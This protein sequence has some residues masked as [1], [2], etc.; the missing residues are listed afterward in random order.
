MTTE[1][2]IKQQ[3]SDNRIILYMKGIPK[4][5]QCG[6]SARAVQVLEA[7]GAEFAFVNVLEHPEI[8]Q[9]LPKISNWPTFPQL[10]VAGELIGGSDIIM[11]LYQ[12]GKL[13][14]VIADAKQIA[15]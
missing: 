5:P 6:F 14:K 12:E 7:C 9:T 8:R 4:I 11:Q 1:A 13:Q 2:D 3:I 10:Y 15:Q